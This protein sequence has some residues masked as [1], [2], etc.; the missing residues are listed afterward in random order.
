M[1]WFWLLVALFST[2]ALAEPAHN[3]DV[4]PRDRV[5]VAFGKEGLPNRERAPA[6]GKAK[7]AAANYLVT[8]E[9]SISNTAKDKILDVLLRSG[10]VVKE[11]YNYRVFKGILFTIPTS[12]DKGLTAWEN[13][14]TKQEGVKYVEED[15]LVK[16]Q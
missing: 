13:A 5:A 1:R 16:T 14:L 8:L 4:A 3:H 6:A 11:E 12:A 9:R 15:Q 10:A 7:E 2:L